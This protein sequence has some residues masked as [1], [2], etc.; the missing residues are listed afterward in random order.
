M[1]ENA[2]NLA[3]QTTMMLTINDW[4][5]Q[6]CEEFLEDVDKEFRK[7]LKALDT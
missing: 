2:F 7:V 5:P 6:D 3:S 4:L 1:A